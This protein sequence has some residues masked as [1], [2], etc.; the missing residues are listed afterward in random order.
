MPIRIPQ[1]VLP[2]TVVLIRRAPRVGAFP[3]YPPFTID[4]ETNAAWSLEG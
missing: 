2:L 1:S 4:L 3:T